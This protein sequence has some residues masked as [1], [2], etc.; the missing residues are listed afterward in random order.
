LERTKIAVFVDVENLTQWIK[1]GGPEELLSELSSIG[2]IIV[3][4]A[5]GNWAN[6]NLQSFQGELNRQGFE[7][8]HNFHPVSGKNSSDIQLTIDVIE[9]ALRLTD[10]EW[11]VLAT[12]DS[13]FSPLF[14]RLREM[15]KEVI[16]TGPRSP[17]SESV[18]TSCSKFIY[19]D[20]VEPISNE[21]LN[22]SLDDAIDLAE[23]ALKTFDAPV[24]CSVLK[25]SMINID[26]A[27]DEKIF[28]FKSFTDFLKS[29][30][31][32][33]LVFDTKKK[34]YNV[35]LTSKKE[36]ITQIN[37]F[38]KDKKD[39]S[40]EKLYRDFLR[41][42][43][44]RSVPQSMLIDIYR[45]MINLEP[46]TRTEIAESVMQQCNGTVSVTIIKKALSIF[47]KASLFEFTM[48]NND[49]SKD[50]KWKIK[51]N[52]NFLIE[53]DKA[54]V[55]RLLSSIEENKSNI[56]WSVILSVLYSKY[57]EKEIKGLISE[58]QRNNIHN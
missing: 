46:L 42:K 35:A 47:M 55:E 28:G 30:E 17:L 56:Y 22:S 43:G 21:V 8:I 52:D 13:D 31:F 11:F 57:S 6:Q 39:H 37:P 20:K 33:N 40:T 29:I 4:R 51:K 53:I 41:K 26:S 32:I 54:I 10:V 23:K 16:G 38:E 44:W 24:L 15:G 14:R 58:S 2:Q 5:Y 27:F 25:K 3:R 34:I 45:K 18:K 36:V 19:T 48:Q 7:L 9:H 49:E 12:G 1:Y 50:K